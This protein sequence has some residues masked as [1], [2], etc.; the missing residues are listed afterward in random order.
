MKRP[1]GIVAAALLALFVV[2][3]GPGNP[4]FQASDITGVAFGRAFKLTDHNGEPRAL[5][6][7]RGKVLVMFFHFFPASILHDRYFLSIE[8]L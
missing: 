4:R 8:R 2:A 1:F 6:E 5:A 3:C 7:S